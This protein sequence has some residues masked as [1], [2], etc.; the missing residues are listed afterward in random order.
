MVG[1]VPTQAKGRLVMKFSKFALVF[2]LMATW[3]VFAPNTQSLAQPPNP[4]SPAVIAFS[5][6]QAR[7]YTAVAAKALGMEGL[8][9]RKA[10]T[11]GKKLS[12]IA[13]RQKVA[14]ATL[15]KALQDARKAEIDQLVQADELTKQEADDLQN[16]Q[17]SGGAGGLIMPGPGSDTAPMP[18]GTP[19]MSVIGPGPGNVP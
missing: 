10:L 3:L 8:A 9:L 16:L 6:C 14:L 12:D 2:T 15:T 4:P 1:D 19:R 13:S 11:Q 5:L 17:I 18:Q 7:D